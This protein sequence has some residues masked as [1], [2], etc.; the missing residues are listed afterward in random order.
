MAPD[1]NKEDAPELDNTDRKAPKIVEQDPKDI[2]HK[3][4]SQVADV[5]PQT[6][7]PGHRDREEI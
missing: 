4:Q 6:V 1:R 7:Q 3:G 5:N 2:P